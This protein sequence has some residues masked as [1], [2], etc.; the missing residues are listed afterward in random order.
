MLL[1]TFSDQAERVFA[2]A[3]QTA[4]ELRQTVVTGGHVFYGILAEGGEST[5]G[6]VLARYKFEAPAMKAILIETVAHARDREHRLPGK[7]PWC[8][9]AAY[10]TRRSLEIA[11]AFGYPSCGPTML[12]LAIME[13]LERKMESSTIGP[14]FR[15]LQPTEIEDMRDEVLA[16]LGKTKADLEKVA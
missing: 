2:I 11:S 16:T 3:N 13:V 1:S 7:P 4:N 15:F 5:A 12:L 9:S 6:T 8:N 10:I 14:M